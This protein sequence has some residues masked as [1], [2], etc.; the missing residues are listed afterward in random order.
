MRQRRAEP[1]AAAGSCSRS[2]RPDGVASAAR[3]RDLCE[4][5]TGDGVA[6]GGAQFVDA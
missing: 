1:E 5:V 4:F 6:Q 2:V 3:A